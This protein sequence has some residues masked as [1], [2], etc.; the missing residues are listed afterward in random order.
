MAGLSG[1]NGKW[2]DS[3]E[4]WEMESSEMNLW[5]EWICVGTRNGF[6]WH[7]VAQELWNEW[8]AKTNLMVKRFATPELKSEERR[9]GNQRSER[10]VVL[11]PR[12]GE[13]RWSQKAHVQWYS[14]GE[15]KAKDA[16]VELMEK[17]C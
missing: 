4:F 10:L 9:G 3:Q 2:L 8:D 11:N 7:C 14:A 13:Y 1:K 15:S 5:F 6:V 12:E 16:L 17:F